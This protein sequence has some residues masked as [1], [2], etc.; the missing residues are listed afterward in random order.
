MTGKAEDALL[1]TW[2][3]QLESGLRVMEA[4]IEGSIRIRELQLEAATQAHA[5]VVATRQAVA[6]ATD[7]AQLIKLQTDWLQAN[8]QK[9]FE[10]WRSA[11]QALLETDAAVAKQACGAAPLA[12]PEKVAA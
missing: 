8:A 3:T 9:S 6:A 2:K 12:V 10:Y 5:D 4:I 1:Q 11:H 7:A